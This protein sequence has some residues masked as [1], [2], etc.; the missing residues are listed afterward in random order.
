MDVMKV[1]KQ[2]EKMMT[3]DSLDDAQALEL[4]K[5]LQS[6][7]ISLEDLEKTRIGM[8]VNK[9]RKQTSSSDVSTLAKKLI[10]AWK[11]MLDSASNKGSKAGKTSSADPPESKSNSDSP[12]AMGDSPNVPP[13]QEPASPA[14]TTASVKT[15]SASAEFSARSQFVPT[16]PMPSNP[17]RSKCVE[18]LC[19]AMQKNSEDAD[20]DHCQRTALSIEEAICS[21][22]PQLDSKYRNRV[23]SRVANLQDTK[24]PSLC[25]NVMSGAISPEKLA[26]M[27]AEEMASDKMKELRQH[28]TKEGVR[29]AQMSVNSGTTTDLLKCSKCKQRKCTYNQL[30]TRSSDEPMTTFV[31]C[32]HCGHRWKFC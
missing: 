4:L 19:R 1:S 9:I 28:F 25:A 18:M 14:E 12:V 22:M 16:L 29:D 17:V 11:K 27:T 32:Q 5:V 15:E 31:F 20:E 13:K 26:K 8:S 23:R 10:K 30:Q 24:N 21:E 3:E 7:S 2:L 6:Q